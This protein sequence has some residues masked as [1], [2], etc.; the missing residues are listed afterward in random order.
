MYNKAQGQVS[1]VH[2]IISAEY[3]KY[4]NLNINKIWLFLCCHYLI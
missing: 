1:G 2:H 3:D 4:E